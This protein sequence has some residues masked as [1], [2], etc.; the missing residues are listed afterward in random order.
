MAVESIPFQLDT[1]LMETV[2]LMGGKVEMKGLA[3]IIE[4]EPE[5]PNQFIGDQVR[6]RQILA[7]LI[8]NAVKFTENGTIRITVSS[9]AL[10]ADQVELRVHV[11][12]SGIGMSREQ[13]QNLCFAQVGGAPTPGMG[14][15]GFGLVISKRLVELMGGVVGVSSELGRGSNFWFTACLR[16]NHDADQTQYDWSGLA[17]WSKPVLTPEADARVHKV[18]RP[19]DVVVLKALRRIEGINLDRGLV[20]MSGKVS[21]YSKLLRRFIDLKGN[22]V[23]RIRNALAQEDWAEARRLAHTLKSTVGSL[24]AVSLQSAASALEKVLDAQHPASEMQALLN[25]L[26]CQMK[27]LLESSNSAFFELETEAI[28]TGSTRP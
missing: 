28:A 4:V 19:S 27:Q 20:Y 15:T 21:L 13:M 17:S 25:A 5:T 26:E 16:C 9:T 12:D 8:N 10:T 7:N 11:R 18:Q 3:L 1:L 2:L 23:T 14:G 6:L 22:D 24:G